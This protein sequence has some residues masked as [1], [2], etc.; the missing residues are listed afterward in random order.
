MT[1]TRQTFFSNL[2]NS[3]FKIFQI[4][5]EFLAK[6]WHKTVWTKLSD[7]GDDDHLSNILPDVRL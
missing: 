6:F 4:K 1:Q 3:R 2:Q 5:A 7:E